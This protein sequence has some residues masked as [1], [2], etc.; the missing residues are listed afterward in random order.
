MNKIKVILLVV[1]AT[2]VSY[3][4]TSQTVTTYAGVDNSADPTNNFDNTTTTLAAAKFYNP[5]NIGWDAN[6]KMYVVEDHKIRVLN[7]N[8]YIRSGKIGDPSFAHGYA[9]GTGIAN[10]YNSPVAVAA[11]SNGDMY[12][13]DSE[14]HA[15]RKLSKFVNAGNGQTA[16]TF[17][18]AGPKFGNGTAGFTNG[19]G[20][21]A[22]CDTPKGMTIDKDGNLYVAD[23][24]N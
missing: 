6:G 19:T 12:I 3:N 21:A 7:G 4:A 17:A 14:N 23:N 13:L 20:T 16:S 18:G 22:R 1:L 24:F 10:H 5:H 9:N 2:M 15:I 8:L 11:A